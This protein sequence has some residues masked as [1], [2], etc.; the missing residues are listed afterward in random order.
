M[1]FDEIFDLTAGVHFY[2][3]RIY[4]RWLG[5]AVGWGQRVIY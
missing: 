4:S 1:S 2:F 3:Y 5:T